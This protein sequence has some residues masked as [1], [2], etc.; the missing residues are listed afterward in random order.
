MVTKFSPTQKLSVAQQVAR[1][2]A[3]HPQFRVSWRGPKARW[4]GIVQPTALSRRYRVDL[5]Y[6]DGAAPTV[7]VV[8]PRLA[9]RPDNPSIPHV[10]EGNRPCLYRPNTGEWDPLQFIAETVVPWLV[11]WLFYY[12]IW[13]ATGEWLGGGEHP[14]TG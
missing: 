8:E 1:M 13:Q 14:P 5:R 10:Y 2:S 11:L 6:D 7:E 3:L 12:E 4:S 9:G